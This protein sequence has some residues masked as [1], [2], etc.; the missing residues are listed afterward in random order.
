MEMRLIE[1]S[2]LP[3]QLETLAK[4]ALPHCLQAKS[5]MATKGD[6]LKIINNKLIE[7][8]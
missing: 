7:Q 8:A 6:K 3:P 1:L 4:G 2:P 5:K